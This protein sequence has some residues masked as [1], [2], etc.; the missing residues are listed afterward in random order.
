MKKRYDLNQF[1]NNATKSLQELEEKSVY[2]GYFYQSVYT[3][4]NKFYQKEQI[5]SLKFDDKWIK[6]IESYFPSINRITINLKSTLKMQSEI[7]PIEKTKKVSKDSII[8]LMSHSNFIKEV[9]DNNVVPKQILSARPEI[10]YGIYENR[11]IMTLIVR[12]RDF[13]GKRVQMMRRKLKSRKTVHL[14]L[15][16]E[17]S[18]EESDFALEVDIKQ[19]HEVRKRGVD[20][21]NEMVL[22]RAENLLKLVNRL[23]NTQFMQ[24]LRRFKQVTSPIMKTQVILSNPDFNNAYLLW[25][26]LD[27][28]NE[29][30]Y[31]LSVNKVNKRF[32]QNYTKQLNQALMFL[33]SALLANDKSADDS[34]G[35]DASSYT[36]PVYKEKAAKTVLSL[37]SEVDIDPIKFQFEEMQ[38][39]EYYLSKNTQILKQQFNNLLN[40]GNSPKVALKKALADTLRITNALYESFFEIDADEDVFYQ[41]IKEDDPE[42]MYK[43]AYDKYI[44]ACSVREV[45]E[46]DFKKTIALEKKW[47]QELL[48]Y[49]KLRLLEH[50]EK[51]QKGNAD[52]LQQLK[53]K[54]KD[55]L[56]VC[57]AKE[58][59]EKQLLLRKHRA[60]T[61][62]FRKKL[63]QEYRAEKKK[64][65]ME[66]KKKLA[67]ERERLRKQAAAN[68]AKA[69]AQLKETLNKLNAEHAERM[70]KMREEHKLKV[71]QI[72]GKAKQQIAASLQKQ[73]DQIKKSQQNQRLKA[74]QIIEQRKKALKEREAKEKERLKEELR[75]KV[76]GNA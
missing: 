20:E 12:L 67:A 10:E 70:K 5:E 26:Y 31:K 61:E 25:L 71:A 40:E 60:E 76:T 58:F 52:I 16:S 46:Q 11:F 73:K 48:K 37:P 39:N 32:T 65:D 38:I 68:Q 43:D 45:K 27:R 69:E 8:H 3:G 28:Y 64:I 59:R 29:L 42:K 15:N 14:N 23:H 6:A 51:A 4:K 74:Q 9:T 75:Q 21:H 34:I 63:N 53:K 35:G 36:K 2:T 56:D 49:H 13:I 7:I 66:A 33:C 55:K 62:V 50:A 30:D 19:T 47:Q 54:Y 22:V 17:F 57:A 24:M 44:I 1:Y 72:K 41:L 18:L